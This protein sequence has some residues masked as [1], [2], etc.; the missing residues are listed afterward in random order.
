MIK[1]NKYSTLL[2][3]R[4]KDPYCFKFLKFISLNCK[5]LKVFWSGNRKKKFFINKKYDFIISYRSSIILK[6]KDISMARIAAI[7]LHP[8]P[9]NYRGIGCLNYALYNNEKK[10]GF[11]IHLIS[12]KIDY[13]KILFV[14]YF[15][16]N[17]KSTVATLLQKT[18]E[19]C[20]KFSKVF[21]RNILK[22]AKKI[23]FYKER[24]D[25]EKWSKVIKN[26]KELNK[27]Y[28]I[29]DFSLSEVKRKI[30][31]TNFFNFKPF[32]QIGKNKFYLK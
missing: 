28:K 25:K 5:S 4:D 13:G 24:F 9:P 20:L 29:E 22:D 3:L 15:S 23:E 27:F 6:N 7:N 26:K 19:Q 32:I 16:I 30:R 11:T 21:F 12:K 18:H 2:L 1:K 8:G 10:F 31:A 14:K 17:K